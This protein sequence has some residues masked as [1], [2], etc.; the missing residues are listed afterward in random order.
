MKLIDRVKE[1][2]GQGMTAEEIAQTVSKELGKDVPVWLV[3]VLM[4]L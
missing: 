4:K 2:A 3:E 1:L